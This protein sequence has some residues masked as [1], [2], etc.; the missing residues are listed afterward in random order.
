MMTM[1][2][3]VFSLGVA[4]AEPVKPTPGFD[5][6]GMASAAQQRSTVT[7]QLKAAPGESDEPDATHYSERKREMARRLVWLMLSAR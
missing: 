3:V 7:T 4:H 5:R 1:M 2:A 6:V